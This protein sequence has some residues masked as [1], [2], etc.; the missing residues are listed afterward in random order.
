MYLSSPPVD[1]VMVIIA[2]VIG[3]GF[4]NL[5]IVADMHVGIVSKN[6]E[7]EVS[8]V[9]Q[10]KSECKSRKCYSASPCGL[11]TEHRVENELWDMFALHPTLSSI[12]LAS[13]LSAPLTRLTTM[14]S[15]CYPTTVPLL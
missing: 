2:V 12:L 4:I 10:E 1:L 5:D 9:I 14:S 3:I 11:T 8:K 15:L 6:G 13:I 7:I